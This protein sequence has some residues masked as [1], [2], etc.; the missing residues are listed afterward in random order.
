MANRF[1][2]IIDSATNRIVELPA[3]DNLDLAGSNISSVANITA[4]NSVTASYFVGTLYGVANSAVVA[5]SA[6]SVAGANVSG[7]VG[8]A[9][10]ANSVAGANVSGTVSSAT[11]ATTAATVTT[12]AQPNITSVGS[13]TGLTVSNASGVVNFITTSNVSLG[14]VANIKV[15]GGSANQYLQTDGAGNLTF[16]TLNA[17]SYQL[18]SV[19]AATI[20]NIA[21][22]GTQTI[23]GI[24]I[25]VGQRVLVKNQTVTADNGIYLCAS[26]SWTRDTDFTT[27]AATL[28]GGVTVGVIGG[29]VNSGTQW[30]C[31]NTTAITIGSTSITFA[32]NNINRI[33]GVSPTIDTAAYVDPSGFSSNSIAFGAG[34]NAQLGQGTALGAFA[35]VGSYG[36]ALGYG[37]K[38]TSLGSL[39]IGILAN[40]VNGTRSIAIG[41]NSTSTK[42]LTVGLGYGTYGNGANAI[43]LAT[44]ANANGVSSVAIGESSKATGNYTISIGSGTGG[45]TSPTGTAGAN[46][47]AIGTGAGFN[48]QGANSIA[49]GTAAQE[50]TANANAIAIGFRAG[51]NSQGA[52][53]IAIGANAGYTSQANNSIIL[54]ASGANLNTTTANS[55][56]VKPIRQNATVPGGFFPLYYNPTTGEIVVVG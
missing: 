25:T 54:N 4:G 32:R 11:S 5:N 33:L 47:I 24:S 50:Q 55:F 48:T 49:I 22:N 12:N 51:F 23:D 9:A 18:Q 27:G 13:L 39:A 16:A 2:L 40:T 45:S 17:A 8:F 44:N 28:L 1:P 42:D 31:T 34:A 52:N 6:N 7:Q 3:T 41:E 14:A 38:A 30:I 29:T 19:V 36:T 21:L 15:T 43:A 53:T 26:G 20:S 46:A 35:N 56:F 37:A 10:V